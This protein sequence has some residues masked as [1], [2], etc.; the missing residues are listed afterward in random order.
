MPNPHEEI[1]LALKVAL[2]KR[3]QVLAEIKASNTP[4]VLAE[5]AKRHV[6][7]HLQIKVLRKGIARAAQIE[8]PKLSEAMR[9]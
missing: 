4:P 5:L 2:E 1:S 3:D 9:G 7:I 6:E 8:I